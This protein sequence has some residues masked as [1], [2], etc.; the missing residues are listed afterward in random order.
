MEA[1]LISATNIPQKLC[2]LGFLLFKIS[3]ILRPA[4]LFNFIL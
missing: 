3:G 1:S 4:P 2:L